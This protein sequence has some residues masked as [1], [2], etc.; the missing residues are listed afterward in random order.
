MAHMKPIPSPING[1]KNN[2]SNKF[3]IYLGNRDLLTISD[4]IPNIR[5]I[6]NIA[7]QNSL[8]L[9]NIHIT[10]TNDRYHTNC[11]HPN[12]NIAIIIDTIPAVI[13]AEQIILSG[14]QSFRSFI[15]TSMVEGNIMNVI[16]I[17]TKLRIILTSRSN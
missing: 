9:F 17:I 14:V 16:I 11:S 2:S 6:I 8:L 3:L 15:K 4:I 1:V 10:P 13:L 7:M 5:M 12:N